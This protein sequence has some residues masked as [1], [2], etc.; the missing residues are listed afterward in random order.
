[1]GDISTQRRNAKNRQL[2]QL[3][4]SP[5]YTDVLKPF[6]THKK[7]IVNESIKEPVNE[8]QAAK[9]NI[10]LVNTNKIINSIVSLIEGAGERIKI[11]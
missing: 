11:N 10:E 4:L 2:A 1:M 9:Q 5:V 6:L 7:N 8:F 3:A